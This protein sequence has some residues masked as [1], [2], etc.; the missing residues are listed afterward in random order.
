M[1]VGKVVA[2]AVSDLEHV[3]SILYFLLEQTTHSSIQS[4]QFL[5][6]P[7]AETQVKYVKAFT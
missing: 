7:P 6:P 5:P 2:E 3:L 4:L 1:D